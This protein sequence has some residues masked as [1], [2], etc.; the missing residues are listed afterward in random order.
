MRRNI[1][2]DMLEDIREERQ[3]TSALGEEQPLPVFL[4]HCINLGTTPTSGLTEVIN[5][6]LKQQC[7]H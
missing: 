2:A 3:K 7:H 4:C 6:R 1:I 5:P